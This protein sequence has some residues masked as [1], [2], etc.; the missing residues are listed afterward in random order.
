MNLQ[1]LPV[2]LSLAVFLSVALSQDLVSIQFKSDPVLVQTG[3][4]A[5]FTVVTVLQVFSITWGYPGGVTPLGLWVGG[6]AVLNTVTQYQGRVTITATQLRIS[7]AQLGDAGNYT[8]KVDPSPTTGLAQNT[9]SIQLR[10]FDAVDG[11]TMFVPSVALEGGNVSVRC[12]WTKG[13]ET[14]VLWGKGGSALTSNSR[15]TI[16]GGDLV[17]NPAR[18]EDAGVYSCTVSN[19]VSAQTASKTLTVYYGPDTPVLSKASPAD[20]VVAA[21]AVVGQTI[22]LT[23]VSNSLPPATFSWKYNNEPVAS[24][25]P[26]SGVFSLQTF[27]TNQSGQYKCVASNAITGATSEQGTDLAIVGTCL[28]AGAVAGIVIGCVVAL[29]LIVIAIVLLVRWKR[30]CDNVA[31][32]QLTED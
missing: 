24:G 21:D 13:T 27:S 29:I 2:I 4:D 12:T 18:R 7:S 3:T 8:V 22:R 5:V 15:V 14:S 25:Q 11:V 32:L 1:L 28:S 31:L 17:I 26:A 19:L 16:K 20:C 30:V 6:S 23:C 10:V 9:R